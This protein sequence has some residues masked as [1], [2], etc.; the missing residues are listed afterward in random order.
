MPGAETDRETREALAAI[1]AGEPD[2]LR[3]GL[4][5]WGPLDPHAGLEEKQLAMVRLAAL[6]ALDAPPANYGWQV[7]EA[8]AA[9]VSPGEMLAVLRAIAPQVGAARAV[10]A[11]PELMLALGLT[12]PHPSGEPG[13]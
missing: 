5:L 12:L 11:A 7:G 8:L 6:I 10:A 1:A 3:E 2:S 4:G 13:D 9:G